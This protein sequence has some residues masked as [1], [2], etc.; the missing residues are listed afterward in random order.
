MDRPQRE[1]ELDFAYSLTID[2]HAYRTH[3]IRQ[4]IAAVD[5]QT[6][7][8]LEECLARGVP[9]AIQHAEHSSIVSIP[10]NLVGEYPNRS[11]NGSAHELNER[12]LAGERIDPAAMD[13]TRVIGAHQEIP[14]RWR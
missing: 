3:E 5:F 13:F 10:H 7:N 9:L 14:Y 11:G 6:P 4:R 12:F 2:G 1:G 8:Q